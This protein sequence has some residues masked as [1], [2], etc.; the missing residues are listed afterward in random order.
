MLK[1]IMAQHQG[2]MRF[3]KWIARVSQPLLRYPAVV[4]HARARLTWCPA[5]CI[6]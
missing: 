4:A 5:V 6:Y 2:Y 3:D 1:T